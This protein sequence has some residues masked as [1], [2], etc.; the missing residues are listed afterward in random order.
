MHHGRCIPIEPDPGSRP[1]VGRCGGRL[2]LAS[3]FTRKEEGEERPH[4]PTGAYPADDGRPPGVGRGVLHHGLDPPAGGRL[5]PVV[6]R[7]GPPGEDA[8]DDA[9]HPGDRVDAV[10]P[11]LAL[12]RCD[13]RGVR[14]SRHLHAL[15]SLAVIGELEVVVVQTLVVVIN[16]S[17]QLLELCIEITPQRVHPDIEPLELLQDGPILGGSSR[18]AE[19]V[20]PSPELG[21]FLGKLHERALVRGSLS[22]GPSDAARL[23]A[24]L[25]HVVAQCIDLAV[26]ALEP[27][28]DLVG[29]HDISFPHKGKLQI[30]DFPV[31][32]CSLMV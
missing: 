31:L 7:P 5:R 11:R 14:P 26:E 23:A 17:A 32:G 29:V 21:H 8:G 1:G 4:E 24:E 28:V 18:G 19:A 9:E 2:G 13:G 6:D 25:G 10:R 27:L 22:V 15:D 30:R 20:R 16:P 3:T 12:E